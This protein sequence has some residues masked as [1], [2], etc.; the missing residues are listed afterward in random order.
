MGRREGTAAGPSLLRAVPRRR[1]SPYIKQ[2]LC[3]LILW[4]SFQRVRWIFA[5]VALRAP[6]PL[7]RTPATATG[8][9]RPKPLTGREKFVSLWSDSYAL[10]LMDYSSFDSGLNCAASMPWRC[11]SL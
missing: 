8:P 6:S 9:P 4:L 10:W 3:Q 1:H 5:A 7:R 11:S 2:G